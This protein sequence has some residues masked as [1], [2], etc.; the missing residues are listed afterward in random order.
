MSLRER[1]PTSGIS[2]STTSNL[3]TTMYLG[4]L[5]PSGRGL[6]VLVHVEDVVRIVLPLDLREPVVVLAVG[7]LNSLLALVHDHVQVGAAGR[8]RMERLL[9]ADRPLAHRAGVG[10]IGID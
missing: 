6:D 8:I 5:L 2:F 10:R 9:V 4:K 1:V 7:G 3:R